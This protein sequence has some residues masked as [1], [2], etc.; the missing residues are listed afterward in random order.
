MNILT[1][2]EVKRTFK[3]FLDSNNT[4]SYSTVAGNIFNATYAIDLNNVIFNDADLDKHY[5]MNMTL[6]SKADTI[7][8]NGIDPQYTYTLYVDM[9]KGLSIYQYR[10]AKLPSTLIPVEIIT[11]SAAVYNSRLLLTDQMS[12]PTFIQNIR[13]LNMITLNVIRTSDNTILVSPVNPAYYVC[14]LTFNEV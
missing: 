14:V 6:I 13:N 10:K 3:I 7:A 2:A 8:N 11:P 12:N 9:G 5:Y 1:K 4:A